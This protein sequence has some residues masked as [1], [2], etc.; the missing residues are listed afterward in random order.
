MTWIW[1]LWLAIAS[2][3]VTLAFVHGFVWLRN[4]EAAGNA[5]FAILAISVAGMAGPPALVRQRP[6]APPSAPVPGAHV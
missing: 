5:A 1:A 4:R 6:N 2:M 3:C